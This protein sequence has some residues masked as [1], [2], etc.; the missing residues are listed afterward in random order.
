MS[1]SYRKSPV[2]GFASAD[3]D[4]PW[5]AQVAR[6][7]RRLVRQTLAQT[8]DGDVL[9]GKRWAVADPWDA[10]KDGKQWLKGAIARWLRK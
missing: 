2:R 3:S 10:P 4:Q 5:K 7:T 8:L 6:A 1:R 9:P